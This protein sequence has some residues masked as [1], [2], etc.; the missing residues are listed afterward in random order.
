MKKENMPA[1]EGWKWASGYD[2]NICAQ[3]SVDD[4]DFS[5]EV[6][7][8]ELEIGIK[9]NCPSELGSVTDYYRIPLSVITAAIEAA[10][11]RLPIA[12]VTREGK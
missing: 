2:T 7:D 5:V 12:G 1:P 9:D 8:G 3:L 6:I 10:G 4:G 11:E